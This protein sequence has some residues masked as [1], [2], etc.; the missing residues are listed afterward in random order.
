MCSRKLWTKN[1]F[2]TFEYQPTSGSTSGGAQDSFFVW[3]LFLIL[4]HSSWNFSECQFR[5]MESIM[6]YAMNLQCLNN[7]SGLDVNLKLRNVLMNHILWDNL[8]R[9]NRKPGYIFYF[10]FIWIVRLRWV[11]V[12]SSE[13]NLEKRQKMYSRGNNQH[14]QYLVVWRFNDLNWLK[15]HSDY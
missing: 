4:R 5:E 1:W 14:I 9:L 15:Q 2:L 7:A 6:E 12:F 8:W 11:T 13:F 10:S 3:N